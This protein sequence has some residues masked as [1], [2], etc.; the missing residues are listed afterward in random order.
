MTALKLTDFLYQLNQAGDKVR[1]HLE[2]RND[3]KKI[4]AIT[5]ALPVHNP[6]TITGVI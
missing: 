3:D 4:P 1:K 5:K 6:Y 2:Q